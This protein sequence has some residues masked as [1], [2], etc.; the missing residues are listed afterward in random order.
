MRAVVA[1]AARS[2]PMIRRALFSVLMDTAH[3]RHWTSSRSLISVA[4]SAL[5]ASV[6][7]KRY[8]VAPDVVQHE[9]SVSL[10]IVGTID[11]VRMARPS[12]DLAILYWVYPYGDFES[13]P[14]SIPVWAIVE[15]GRHEVCLSP[16]SLLFYFCQLIPHAVLLVFLLV[17][18]AIREEIYFR[19]KWL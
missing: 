4:R 13:E 16:G 3:R 2:Q 14:G 10:G 7:A 9:V 17:S 12:L 1:A 6:S 8:R 5:S 18:A 19:F 11:G 15:T